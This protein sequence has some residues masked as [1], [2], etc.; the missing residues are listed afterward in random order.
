MTRTIGLVIYAI[1]LC[2]AALFAALRQSNSTM[3]YTA[4]TSMLPNHLVQSDDL[5][6]GRAMPKTAAAALV[7]RYARHFIPA[8][9]RVSEE[10]FSSMPSLKDVKVALLVPVSRSAILAG[11][12]AGRTV[13]LCAADKLVGPTRAQAVFCETSDAASCSLVV[14]ISPQLSAALDARAVSLHAVP[15]NI[16]CP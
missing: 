13:R 2:V 4:H 7:G 1:L 9:E 14:E 8:G 12:D 5:D 10:S 3:Y 16:A 15:D 11:I 6:R